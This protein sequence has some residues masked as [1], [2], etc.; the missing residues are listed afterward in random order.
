MSNELLSVPSQFKPGSFLQGR[1]SLAV[2]LDVHEAASHATLLLL[3]SGH[4]ILTEFCQFEAWDL[5][6]PLT[7]G[8]RI[9]RLTAS[10]NPDWNA[11]L[12]G[13]EFVAA[14]LNDHQLHGKEQ[15]H[16]FRVVPPDSAG[17]DEMSQIEG[18]GGIFAD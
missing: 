14:I 3:P 6:P 13:F 17:D 12:P 5:V 16:R 2:V 4:R 15:A 18:L 8:W 10:E 9:E 7:E 11:Y 1:L